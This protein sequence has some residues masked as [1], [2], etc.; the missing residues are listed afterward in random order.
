MITYTTGDL[1][2]A[3]KS[4]LVNPVN[5]EGF[6]GKGIAL[7]FRGMFPANLAAYQEACRQKQLSPGKLLAVKDI[8]PEL[9]PK[10]IINFVTKVSWRNPSTYGYILDGLVALRKMIQANEIESIAIPALGCGNGGLQ[11]KKVKPL[12]EYHLAELPCDISIYPPQ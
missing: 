6:M 10:L 8:H 11:W 12:M 7:Q 3:D 5:T 9:G 2:Q 1:L 4:A